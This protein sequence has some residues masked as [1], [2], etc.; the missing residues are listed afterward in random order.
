MQPWAAI[1]PLL[2]SL[3]MIG[4]RTGTIHAGLRGDG[5]QDHGEP[6]CNPIFG[7]RTVISLLYR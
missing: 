7:F 4:S 1:L 3:T 5:K 2:L 6:A